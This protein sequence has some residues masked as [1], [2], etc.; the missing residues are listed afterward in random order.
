MPFAGQAPLLATPPPPPPPPPV[1]P[2]GS[3]GFTE[4]GLLEVLANN[5]LFRAA[6]QSGRRRGDRRPSTFKAIERRWFAAKRTRTLAEAKADSFRNTEAGA[7]GNHTEMIGTAAILQLAKQPG[8]H[9]LF[10][11]EQMDQF[12]Q[13]TVN[14]YVKRRG[15]PAA[16]SGAG[17]QAEPVLTVGRKF[18]V[19][20]SVASAC[21]A[22]AEKF[23]QSGKEMALSMIVRHRHTS[24]RCRILAIAQMCY[25]TDVCTHAVAE[26]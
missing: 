19:L 3:G 26:C 20:P 11:V 25:R 9:P 8:G 10:S 22:Y 23:Q 16:K 12:I 21:M 18:F 17:R 13:I 4:D 24:R 6:L 7:A 15:R 1:G 5:D 2:D 14:I